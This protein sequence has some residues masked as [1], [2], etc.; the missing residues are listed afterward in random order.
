MRICSACLVLA[1]GNAYAQSDADEWQY[2]ITPY[3]WLPT[4]DGTLKYHLPPGG[5]G[6]G[7]GHI[8]DIEVGPSDWLDLLNFG[9]LVNGS[10]KKGRFTVFSDIVYLSLTSKDSRVASVDDT[11]SVPGVPV[12]IPISANLNVSTRT[13]LDGLVWSI[14]GGYTIKE[15]DTATMDIFAGVR[16]F[17][18]DFSSSWDLTVDITT[19]GGSV[20]LPSRAVSGRTLTCGTELWGFTASS[21]CPHRTGRS[22]TTP[23]SVPVRPT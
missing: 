14:A 12:P 10:A 9:L 15:T 13:D 8:V 20:V 3:L 4:I 11:I 5:G 7:G 19:P 22:C 2:S 6:G 21:S 18:L 1:F 23:T 16:Y 17:G